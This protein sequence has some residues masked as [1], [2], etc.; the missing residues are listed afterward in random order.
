MIR[1][2]SRTIV[3]AV[4]VL[5]ASVLVSLFANS[6]I[7]SRNG[8]TGRTLK[9]NRS[10][11]GGCHGSSV[12]ASVSATLTG[13]DTVVTGKPATYTLRIS[14]GPAQGAGCDIAAKYGTLAAV[15][16]SLKLSGSELTQRSNTAMTAGVAAFEFTYTAPGSRT[17][18]TLYALGL[19]T[20]SNGGTSGDAWNWSPNKGIVI[21]SSTTQTDNADAS[22]AVHS[23]G[24]NA[25]NPFST[26]TLFH[27][28][29]ARTTFATLRVYSLTGTVVA[30]VVN[31]VI[32]QGA[33][34][35]A[36]NAGTLPAGIYLYR[37]DAGSF[38]QTRTL[39][40]AR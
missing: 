14:G 34:T 12:T 30:T 36:W 26:N 9:S 4:M 19:S 18:D 7:A 10:G 28:S 27:F 3:P 5:A 20:N 6:G 24:L 40:I 17:S 11:C 8:Y 31:G 39:V 21:V 23:L 25:P 32:P 13:P 29:V 1:T 2:Y 16:S 15:S 33:H 38:S 22:A 35:V 37:L